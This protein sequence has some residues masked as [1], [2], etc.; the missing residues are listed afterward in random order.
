MTTT[1]FRLESRAMFLSNKLWNRGENSVFWRSVSD[2]FKQTFLKTSKTLYV[3]TNNKH[4]VVLEPL[5]GGMSEKHNVFR[6][7]VLL[8]TSYVYHLYP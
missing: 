4:D 3:K 5:V 8:F 6:K 2:R 1:N 7:I